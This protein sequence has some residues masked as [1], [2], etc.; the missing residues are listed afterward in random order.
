MINKVK[1]LNQI[2]QRDIKIIKVIWDG[3]YLYKVDGYVFEGSTVDYEDPDDNTYE[4]VLIPHATQNIVFDVNKE[5]NNL[6][7]ENIGE[8][9]PTVRVVGKWRERQYEV[10]YNANPP[11]GKTLDAG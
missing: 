1:T 8:G 10:H 11:A 6:K 3:N 9:T 4:D 5:F 2:K 7:I